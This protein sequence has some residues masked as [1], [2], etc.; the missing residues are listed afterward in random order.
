[1]RWTP[2]EV[3]A[4]I[5]AAGLVAV[6]LITAIAPMILGQ[7]FSDTRSKTIGNLANAF[8]AVLAVYVGAKVRSS[9]RDDN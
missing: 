9:G 1:M 5:I 8:V 3:V 7:P 2:I 6:F 4:V